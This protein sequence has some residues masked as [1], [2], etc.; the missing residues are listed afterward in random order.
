MRLLKIRAGDTKYDA[1]VGPLEEA[2]AKLQAFS[3]G[4]RLSAV[5]DPTIWG[6]HGER[7]ARIITVDPILV[8]PGEAAKSWAGLEALLAH[9]A[10]RDI[11]RSTPIIAF[12]GGSIGDLTG[13][14]AG[15][16]KRG[17]PV[18]HI[19]TTLL[20]QVDSAIGGKS[21][22][23][24]A[25]RK[26][27]VGL[28]HQPLFVAADP[29]LLDTLDAR[30]FRSGYAEFIKYGLIGD[31]PVFFYSE[32]NATKILARDPAARR[33]TVDL[34]I[35]CKA[36]YVGEDPEDRLGV[37]AKL[38]FGHTFGHAIEAL[39]GFGPVLH[40]EAVALGMGLAFKLS[41]ELGFCTQTDCDRAIAHLAAIGLPTTL[42]E[43]GLAGRGDELAAL[44]MQDKK[45]NSA[46][47]RLILVRGIGSAF[48]CGDV[49]LDRLRAFLARAA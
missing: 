48:V 10:E 25:G 15:L 40:G 26:N 6:L 35:R 17:C 49:T 4:E 21:A 39:T 8:E 37:R 30:Q 42:A 34:A 38:N 5:T 12:G 3:G 20:A 43:V 16:Y 11:K 23:D 9:L 45:A 33:R 24:F 1:A 13:L 2:Q 27:L 46:G 7:L 44:M 41:T 19:P 31:P 14:A 29:S 18:I 28:F 36:H 32:E 47:L 22:I